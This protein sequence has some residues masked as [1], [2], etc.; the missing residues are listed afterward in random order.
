MSNMS[1]ETGRPPEEIHD[2]STLKSRVVERLRTAFQDKA[3]NTF[4]LAVDGLPGTGKSTLVQQLVPAFAELDGIGHF[5][6]SVDDFL[7]TSRNS[8]RWQAIMETEDAKV[9]WEIFYVRRALEHLLSEIARSNGR[10]MSI[11]FPEEYTTRKSLPKIIEIPEGRKV[12]TVEGVNSSGVV[13]DLRIMVS[14]DPAIALLRAVGRDADK[15]K[16]AVEA[17]QHRLKEYRHM[18]PQMKR[19]QALADFIFV[20]GHDARSAVSTVS[21]APQ[22]ADADTLPFISNS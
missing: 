15:G 6:V 22:S 7:A 9:F 12:V 21:M 14:V 20:N 16:N 13:R 19:N 17:Y 8:P 1:C 3:L 2:I 5:P 18:L 4:F 10:A 11:Q